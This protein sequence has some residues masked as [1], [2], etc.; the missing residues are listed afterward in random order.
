MMIL[1]RADAEKAKAKGVGQISE[2]KCPV[3]GHDHFLV[4]QRVIGDRGGILEC[5]TGNYRW[6]AP[7]WEVKDT[8]RMKKPHWGWKK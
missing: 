7:N 3:K 6:L 4:K 2:H 5:P 1:N 8:L